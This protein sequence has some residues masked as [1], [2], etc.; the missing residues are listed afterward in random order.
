MKED[1][2]ERHYGIMGAGSI[3]CYVGG[4]LA[5]AGFRVTL[6]GRAGLMETIRTDGLSVRPQ[7]R[8]TVH[9]LPTAV[10]ASTE[11]D[12]LLACHVVLVAVK[13]SATAAAGEEL[14]EAGLHGHTVVSLQNGIR[15]PGVLRQKLPRANILGG[16]VSFNVIQGDRALFAQATSGP[17][18]LEAGPVAT[19]IAADLRRAGLPLLIRH[20]MES[21]QWS[22]LLLNLNNAVNA[23]AGV[24]VRRQLADRIYRRIVAAS[25]QEGLAVF[26]RAGIKMVSFGRMVPKLAPPVLV[27]PD[28][29]FF[30]VAA[31]M[32]NIDPEARSS[33][34]DDLARGRKTEVEQL[35]GEIV[36]LG[37]EVGVPTP[38]NKAIVD[39]VHE[40]ERRAGGSPCMSAVDLAAAVGVRA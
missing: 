9:I 35:N 17:V 19:M 29:L 22:T 10:R 30:R 39:L 15:N 31:A 16:I 6:V 13:S 12:D 26:A 33:M 2:P 20:D 32:V 8:E 21:V 3:G 38:V 14:A 36:S 40:A 34:A 5:A 25:M 11:V 18:V 27:L 37:A 1:D 4:L 23:L 7:G 24:P 28:W